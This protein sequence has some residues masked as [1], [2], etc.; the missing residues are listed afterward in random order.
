[1]TDD[2]P[3]NGKRSQ[4]LSGHIAWDKASQQFWSESKTRAG[5]FLLK[6]PE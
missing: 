2:L 4:L 6:E 3:Q 1:M 5:V